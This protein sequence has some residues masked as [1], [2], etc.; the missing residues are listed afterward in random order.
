MVLGDAFPLNVDRRGAQDFARA[1][2]PSL[3]LL[4][5]HLLLL[6]LIQRELAPELRPML[7]AAVWDVLTLF[8]R[9][10][11]GAAGAQSLGVGHHRSSWSIRRVT[12]WGKGG[13]KPNRP[14]HRR[15]VRPRFRRR[16]IDSSGLPGRIG[17]GQNG[18]R[19]QLDRIA[20]LLFFR[21][22]RAP[23]GSWRSFATA[24]G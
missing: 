17:L 13:C 14:R 24:R 21:S 11:P 1:L 6:Q 22:A 7:R 15:E 3:V 5:D 4:P 19:G 23:S 18:I 9:I 8:A 2:T 20:L 12:R 10:C 16:W